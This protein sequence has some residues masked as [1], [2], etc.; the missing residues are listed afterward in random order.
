MKEVKQTAVSL[1]WLIISTRD[2]KAEYDWF[3]DKMHHCCYG[4]P[5][6]RI[7]DCVTNDLWE[8]FVTWNKPTEYFDECVLMPEMHMNSIE[9]AKSL[10]IVWCDE[11]EICFLEDLNR[12]KQIEAHYWGY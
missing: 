11:N 8:Y 5:K 2:Y 10:L 6:N 7:T 4:V 1:S 12:Y 9:E 3:W